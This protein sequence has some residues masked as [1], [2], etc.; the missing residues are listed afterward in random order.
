MT[1]MEFAERLKRYRKAKNFTQQELADLL[2]VSNKSVSRWESGGGYPDIVLLGPLAR[3][4]DVTVDALLCDEPPIRTLNTADWQN[5]LSFAFA[6][7]GGVLFFLLDLFTPTLVCYLLYLGAMAYGVYLQ[8]RYTYHSRWFRL[9]N[10]TMNFFVNFVSCGLVASVGWMLFLQG[11]L[12][13]LSSG[14]ISFGTVPFSELSLGNIS[15]FSDNTNPLSSLIQPTIVLFIIQALLAAL[16]TAFTGWIIR[17]VSAGQ[18][19]CLTWNGKLSPWDA[20]PC[21]LA[22]LPLLFW[23]VYRTLYVPEQLYRYQNLIY[24]MLSIFGCLVCALILWR[25]QRH[26]LPLALILLVTL[27]AIL[28]LLADRSCVWSTRSGEIFAVDTVSPIYLPFGQFVWPM[29]PWT[30][31]FLLIYFSFRHIRINLSNITS[32]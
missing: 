24:A 31:G 5:L 20:L 19:P 28:W 25:K 30:A 15:L 26:A 8:N 14:E 29:V 23:V 32:L 10:L 21:G 1:E 18:R 7:G 11:Y 16:L 17:A 13:Y 2:G 22:L 3:A 4:L 27:P 12:S 6:I 9:A